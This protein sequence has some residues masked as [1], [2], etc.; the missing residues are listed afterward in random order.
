MKT[1]SDPNRARL[2]AVLA[3][4]RCAAS[5]A[6]VGA[7][8]RRRRSRRR[9]DD[10]TEPRATPL[11][12]Q[13]ADK[14]MGVVNC[15]NSLCHGSVQPMEGFE[16]AADRV[17][18]LVARRQARARLP[19]A[20]Q[21]AVAAHRAQPRARRSRQRGEALPR[22]PRA[23]RAR[24]RSAASASSSTTACRARRA[25]ARRDAGSQS[26]VA[27]RR[28][29]RRQSEGGPVSDRRSG[30]ARAAVPVVP[31]RQ[32]RPLRHAPDDGRGPSAHEL[33]ARHVHRRRAG[34]LQAR[35]RLGE[36]QAAV[37]WRQGLGDR[38]GARRV[39]DDGRARRSEARPRRALPRARAV[40]LPRLPSSDERQALGAADRRSR[41]GQ[42]P[43]QRFVDADGAADFARRRSAARDAH[44]G[45]DDASLQ[46]TVSGG[47]DAIAQAQDAEGRDGSADRGAR[48]A[49][50]H[51]GR[52]ARGIGR[53]SSTTA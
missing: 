10:R 44:C 13:A 47:G 35:H 7:S 22:L 1:R 21:R 32:R 25:T 40:R 3:R 19:G 33:R 50:D 29:A 38:A 16:R 53:R 12:Y 49:H 8:S 39:R 26:H 5:L 36:A 45:D 42:R 11:P 17:R 23:Q 9:A 52:H 30:R 4:C 2:D 14:S 43:A 18:H 46:Q 24:W 28:D 34:A 51:R 27:G 20:V 6:A 31:F 37:G 15:A 41:T 48:Q